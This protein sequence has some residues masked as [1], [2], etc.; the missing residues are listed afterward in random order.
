MFCLT[1]LHRKAGIT[2]QAVYESINRARGAALRII[3]GAYAEELKYDYKSLA[4]RN[5]KELREAYQ[6]TLENLKEELFVTI[7]ALDKPYA[8]AESQ[9]VQH[10]REIVK[11]QR[12]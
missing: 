4:I 7:R 11:V 2:H 1:I 9:G 5:E 12:S 8:P 10:Q 6:G 3:C